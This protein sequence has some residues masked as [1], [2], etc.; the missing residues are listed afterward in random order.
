MNIRGISGKWN[1]MWHSSPSPK[2]AT[3]S[4]GHWFASASSIRSSKFAS[5]CGA[6]I[7]QELVGLGQVLAVRPLPFEEVR[8]GVEAQAVDPQRQP[9][10]DHAQHRRADPGLSKFRSGWWE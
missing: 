7:R 10:V 5:T 8:D 6:Q 2:Y 1:A 4:S 9:E 3:A